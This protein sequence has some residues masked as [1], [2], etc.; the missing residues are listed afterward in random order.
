MTRREPRACASSDRSALARALFRPE[1]IALVG[2]SSDPTALTSRP[3]RVLAAHGF[4]GRIIPVS[5]TCRSIGGLPAYPSIAD[6]P[7]GARHALVMTPATA[8]TRSIA[9]CG[10][11]GIE[12]ATILTAGF[13][14][15]GPSGRRRQEALV[16]VA[17]RAG[18]RILGPNS[19]GVVDA[20]ALMTLS[21]NAVFEHESLRAGGLS[22]ISQS[23]SMLGAVVS[24]AQERGLG[25]AKLVSVGNEC[26]IGVGELV[27][28]LVDDPDTAVILL[29]LEALRDAPRLAAAARRAFDVGKPVIAYKLGRSAASRQLA[30][31]HTGATTSAEDLTDAYFR[32]HGILRVHVFEALF[33]MPNLVLGSRPARSRRLASVTVSGGAAAMVLDGLRDMPIECVAPPAE[34]VASLAKQNVR[35]APAPVVDLPM[36]RADQGA[37]ARVLSAL[38]GSPHCDIVLAVLGSNAAYLPESARERIL[39]ADRGRKPLAVFLGPRAVAAERMLHSHGVAAFRTPEACADAIRAYAGWQAPIAPPPIDESARSCV[40]AAVAAAARTGC[41]VHDALQLMHALGIETATSQVIRSGT[42]P[43]DLAFPVAVKI[44]S[45]DIP[46]KSDLGGVVLDVASPQVLA[47]AVVALKA[48]VAATCPDARIEGVLVQTMQQGVAEMLLGFRYD[49]EVGPVVVL[50]MGGI[51]TDLMPQRVVRCAPI[52]L[53]S[54]R[55]MIA[56]LPAAALLQGYRGRAAGDLEAL[57]YAIRALSRLALAD[58]PRVLEAEINPLMVKSC[59]VVAV[60]AWASLDRVARI[61][62]QA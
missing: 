2:V 46:H 41:N 24:R 19:L 3:L 15:L 39:A 53:A 40:G 48:R 54:A 45:R 30:A 26:D 49:A 10:A 44:L 36:G 58:E 42:E 28:L 25:F 21:A 11:A 13:A 34:V 29:F 43:L 14:E 16:D 4:P 1:S 33:E 60:D 6:I 27:D 57:A 56:A 59:G 62:P 18:V 8:V 51:Y 50:G 12:V 32:D 7:E 38:L 17:R 52:D 22:V 55:E 5:D 23:G 20:H 35:I 37:Y 9:E 31:T 47:A 61:A